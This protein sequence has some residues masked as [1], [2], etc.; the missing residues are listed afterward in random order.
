M[1]MPAPCCG[2]RRFQRQSGVDG[3]SIHVPYSLYFPP[4]QA[5]LNTGNS[6]W[7]IDSGMP[8]LITRIPNKP[9]CGHAPSTQMANAMY[10]NQARYMQLNPQQAA[11]LFAGQVVQ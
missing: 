7:G 11:A 3:R 6:G 2:P 10:N 4:W 5:A 8:D 9:L 1:H